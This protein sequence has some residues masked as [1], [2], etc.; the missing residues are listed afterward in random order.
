MHGIL[1]RRTM[2]VTGIKST[3]GFNLYDLKVDG[4]PWASLM[5]IVPLALLIILFIKNIT[6]NKLS[7]L[8]ATIA[9]IAMIII[10]MRYKVK[11]TD[12]AEYNGANVEFN[13]G[14]YINLISNILI[15]V[16]SLPML[17]LFN[18]NKLHLN[19]SAKT[20]LSASSPNRSIVKICSVCGGILNENDIYC[21]SCGTKY[22]PKELPEEISSLQATPQ[23]VAAPLQKQPAS[24]NE[25]VQKIILYFKYLFNI[26]RK[27]IIY[28]TTEAVSFIE[29]K[30]K[31]VA[32]GMFGIQAVLSALYALVICAKANSKLDFAYSFGLSL[33]IPL[34]KIFILTAIASF[35]LSF[36]FAGI[37]MAIG[38]L[39]KNKLSFQTSLNVAAVRSI[40]LPPITAFAI[41]ISF[42]NA[43]YGLFVFGMGIFAAVCYLMVT[44]PAETKENKNKVPLI[45]FVSTVIL[46]ILSIF[47]MM[48]VFGYK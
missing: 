36:A 19:S 31:S 46:S 9:S 45:I 47:V 7:I 10:L 43:F 27:V 8:L 2:K 11:V 13:S 1:F 15:L 23:A 17:V 21:Q 48:R 28:P 5:L 44:Y 12:V 30:E 32:L 34:F 20:Y 26:G 6:K 33:D 14:Y 18:I 29:A 4:S 25:F 38:S 37:L 42:F 40:T 3:T 16:T 39:F 22:E 24:P 41:I 35:A